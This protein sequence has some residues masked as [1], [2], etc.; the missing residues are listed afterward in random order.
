MSVQDPQL[1]DMPIRAPGNRVFQAAWRNLLTEAERA[2]SEH[3]IRVMGHGAAK[4]LE[5]DETVLQALRHA[6]RGACSHTGLGYVRN[7]TQAGDHLLHQLLGKEQVSQTLAIAGAPATLRDFNLIARNRDQ[8]TQAHRLS[9]NATTLWI[10]YHGQDLPDGHPVPEPGMIVGQA[11][12]T[13]QGLIPLSEHRISPD[14]LWDAFVNLNQQAVNDFPDPASL[15]HVALETAHAGAAPTHTAI[16]VLIRHY[17]SALEN[18][19]PRPLIA[20][21]ITESARRLEKRRQ[22][23]QSQLATEMTALLSLP[24]QVLRRT[25][26]QAGSKSWAPWHR[27]AETA[28]TGEDEKPPPTRTQHH[29]AT[30]DD[31]STRQLLDTLINEHLPTISEESRQHGQGRDTHTRQSQTD[32]SPGPPPRTR[33][34][35]KR[36]HPS[37]GRRLFHRGPHSPGSNGN[38]L[39]GQ[40]QHPRGRRQ[41]RSGGRSVGRQPALARRP[42]HPQLQPD[43]RRLPT[44]RPDP[45]HSRDAGKKRRPDH[46]R[47]TATSRRVPPLANRLAQLS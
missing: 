20:A 23:T 28:P 39:P 15:V 25:A 8:L 27:L 16:R 30:A 2:I 17:T 7:P 29:G 1:L 44:H 24:T 31:V 34:P 37:L 6:A 33:A 3:V 36:H 9:P 32:R 35:G 10:R 22:G 41:A 14:A 42:A 26:A 5:E 46:H 18:T 11:R 4:L 12:I 43:T 45:S 19:G 21:F 40:H 38:W 13:V 47:D